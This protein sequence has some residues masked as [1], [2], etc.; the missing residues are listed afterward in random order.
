MYG[1]PRRSVFQESGLE[2][3]S[4][5][6]VPPA[7]PC[8]EEQ[9]V[10]LVN[11][12]E[13]AALKGVRTSPLVAIGPTG[14]GK[15]ATIK[16]AMRK[17]AKLTA[18]KGIELKIF[19]TNCM[20][21]DSDHAIIRKVASA[22]TGEEYKRGLSISEVMENVA[23]KYAGAAFIALDD[24][25]E[26]ITRK[27]SKLLHHLVS[28]IESVS[29]KGAMALVL[30]GR[31]F[32]FV[33]QD[34]ILV[35][36][37]RGNFVHFP[38][39][40]FPELVKIVEFRS[41]LSFKSGCVRES[42]VKQ[43][44]F[45]SAN[46]GSGDARYAVILLHRAGVVADQE[47]KGCVDVECVRKA[48]YN[49]GLLGRPKLAAVSDL[50]KLVLRGLLSCMRGKSDEFSYSVD[51][52]SKASRFAAEISG[53]EITEEQLLSALE[54]L[55]NKGVLAKVKEHEYCIPSLPISELEKVAM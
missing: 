53:T 45:N 20:V 39:Y 52:I 41:S 7:L 19:Y 9:L 15:T 31:D 18:R 51:E 23:T 47:G 3:L 42:A 36:R 6:Y 50:E 49:F 30:A 32:D 48:H 13:E 1:I 35:S 29:R 46:Y 2:R 5:D 10:R 54:E 25:D 4:I 11:Y 16:L 40:S 24:V 55:V 14:T 34:P 43:I 38:P 33:V 8:R 12:A 26:Y 28:L 27:K 21:E 22:L 44:A 17:L 37:L